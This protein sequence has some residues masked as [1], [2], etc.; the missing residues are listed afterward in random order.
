MT[1]DKLKLIIAEHTPEIQ[2]L[3]DFRAQKSS[4]A[5]QLECGIINAVDAAVE[6]DMISKKERNTKEKLVQA[7][8][9]TKDGKSRTIKY[10]ADRGL[11]CAL[12]PD[13]KRITATTIDI[14]YDKILEF[15]GVTLPE[16]SIGAIFE[17]AI[18]EKESAGTTSPETHRR[19]R[20]DYK[21]FVDK[22]FSKTDIRTI[23][24]A[25]IQNYTGSLFDKQEI[26][27]SSL[28]NYKIMLNTIFKYA[29][30]EHIIDYNPVDS[31]SIQEFSSRC[32]END[33]YS[34]QVIEDEKIL[35][36]SEIEQVKTVLNERIE[37]FDYY[38]HGYAMLFA[39]ETGARS[40][41]IPALKW[42]DVKENA[43]H[44]HGQQ[45]SIR[46]GGH[47]VYFFVPWNKNEKRKIKKTGRLF[48][49]TNAI[50]DILNRLKKNQEAL[51]IESE[52]IFCK[53]DGSFIYKYNYEKCVRKLLRKLGF[54][55]H[56]NHVFR[57]SLNSNVFIPLGIPVT[58]RAR[59]LGH[60][61]E[62]NLRFYSFAGKDTNPGICDLLNSNAEKAENV[63]KPT[64]FAGHTLVTPKVLFFEKKKVQNS[65]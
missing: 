16:Y 38:V 65:L 39:I 46:K 45:L 56:R 59:M 25:K 44:F 20:T 4:V 23:N 64:D 31:I 2:A 50:K 49:L 62:T 6:I 7:V 27:I 15:Y 60:S 12:M 3:H 48:P 18:E 36:P 53:A 24:S 33:S 5:N 42:S 17:R 58:E 41:E 43:I 37:A 1:E 9:V 14:L 29:R 34:D 32:T 11:W 10:Q 19:I 61:V 26:T 40:G 51:G 54:T 47:T 8:H 57:K 55:I 22:K 30:R 13:K 63:E 52:Y 28:K 21:R 35:T